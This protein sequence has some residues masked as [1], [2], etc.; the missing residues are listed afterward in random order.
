MIPFFEFEYISSISIAESKLRLCI[1]LQATEYVHTSAPGIVF[2]LKIDYFHLLIYLLFCLISLILNI[3]I[4]SDVVPSPT[5][6][7]YP[8]SLHSSPAQNCF[9]ISGYSLKIFL[10][11]MLLIICITL[12]GE[13]FGSAPTKN[14]HPQHCKRLHKIQKSII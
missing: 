4:I 13:Y 11:V 3:F 6:P 5:I 8:P 9:L 2:L 14:I 10:A 7:M 1:P 12:E